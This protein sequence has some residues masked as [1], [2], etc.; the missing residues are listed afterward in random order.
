MQINDHPVWI[1]VDS[2][3]NKFGF[4]QLGYW[5]IWDIKKLPYAL[6]EN[7]ANQGKRFIGY[8]S[9]ENQV[10]TFQ[11]ATWNDGKDTLTPHSMGAGKI[12]T[13]AKKPEVKAQEEEAK[14]E[15]ETKKEEEE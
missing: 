12:V 3:S 1:K 13:A 10:E 14:E 2:P 11:E 8:I 4:W 15:E 6:K 9:S 5:N 7:A